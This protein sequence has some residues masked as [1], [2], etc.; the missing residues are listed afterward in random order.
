MPVTT[1]ASTKGELSLILVMV[2]GVPSNTIP[3]GP[4]GSANS[5]SFGINTYS[6]SS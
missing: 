5:I 4:G 6:G 1:P 3:N 2:G